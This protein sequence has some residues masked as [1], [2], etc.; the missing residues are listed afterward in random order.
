MIDSIGSGFGPPP[1]PPQSKSGEASLS[2]EQ[3][4]LIEE[5]LANF[6][7]SSLSSDDAASIVSTFSEAG[8]EPSAEFAELLSEAGFDAREI[9]DLAGVGQRQNQPPQ[10]S[11]QSEGLD[12]TSVASYLESLSNDTS[13]GQSLSSQVAQQ[14]GLS[15]GQSLINVTA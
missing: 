3:T 8:I 1:P 6:D 15:E 9:G 5:T 4:S 7:S 11:A 13:S 10:G 14:F 2:D 12:L